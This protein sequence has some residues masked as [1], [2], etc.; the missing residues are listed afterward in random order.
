VGLRGAVPIILAIFPLMAGLDNARLAFNT[1]FFVVIVSLL[2]Q[3]W[4]ITPAARLLKL[5]VP[6]GSEPVSRLNLDIP[7]HLEY[8]L[9]GYVVSPGSLAAGRLVQDLNL[10]DTAR[11]SAVVRDGAMIPLTQDVVLAPGDYMYIVS[12]P[13]EIPRLN[14]LFDP[15]AVPD[16][17]ERQRFFGDFALNADAALADIEAMY[18]LTFRNKRD[19]DVTLGDL[20]TH[21]YHERPVVGDRIRVGGSELVVQEVADGKIRTVGL[22]LRKS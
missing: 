3:G 4:T 11:P 16:R 7:S 20:L 18:G 5:E 10:P 14:R 13:E 6:P 1:A 12:V 2:V 15:Q 21:A 17:L 22:L 8:E 9:L 19:G